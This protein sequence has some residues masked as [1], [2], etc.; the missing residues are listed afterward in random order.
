MIVVNAVVTSKPEDIAALQSAIHTMEAASREESGC[1]D[2]TFSVELNNPNKL[3]I[4]EKWLS[5][6]ALKAHMATPHMADFQAAMGAHP[7]A[8]LE[9]TFYEVTEIQPF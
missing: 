7:P 8:S 5:L 4:T 3:R 2:Y 1:S 9:V 6:E